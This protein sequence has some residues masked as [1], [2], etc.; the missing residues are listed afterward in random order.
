[1]GPRLGRLS[2]PN[3]RSGRWSL[4]RLCWVTEGTLSWILVLLR[5]WLRWVAGDRD[6]RTW[7][8]V[9]LPAPGCRI[10]A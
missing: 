4:A 10:R 8:R 3:R 9:S 6:P 2:G 1:M 5:S 7:T